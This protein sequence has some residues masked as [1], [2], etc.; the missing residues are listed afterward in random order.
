[1]SRLLGVQ[2]KVDGVLPRLKRADHRWHLIN[3]F[4]PARYG[5]GEE[6]TSINPRTG[7][8]EGI[9]FIGLKF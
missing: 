9:V 7:R 3:P 6:V 2:F 4:A 1:V 8:A 5:F